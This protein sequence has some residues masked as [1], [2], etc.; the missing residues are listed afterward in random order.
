MQYHI[1]LLQDQWSCQ[2]M[3]L[4]VVCCSFGMRALGGLVVLFL[5]EPSS[6]AVTKIGLGTVP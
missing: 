4:E 1:S 6:A 5:L 2:P 3:F